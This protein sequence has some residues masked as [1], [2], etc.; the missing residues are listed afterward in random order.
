MKAVKLFS[1]L[2]LAMVLSGCAGSQR[3]SEQSQAELLKRAEA[4]WNA[5]ESRDWGAAYEFTSPAYRD[6]F[7]RK[8]YERKFSY[9]VE[10]ELTSVEFVNY[11]ARA[12]VASVAV[13]VMSRP[14]KQT[15]AASEAIGAVPVRS[16]E[17]WILSDGQWWYSANL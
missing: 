14:V 6:V 16:V 7:T 3:L 9:M 1:L 11:D 10:W 2:M 15:S 13:G 5:L 17:Q 4:R 8:M 12:A